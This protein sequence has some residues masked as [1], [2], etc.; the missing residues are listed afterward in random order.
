MIS[1]NSPSRHIP[2]CSCGCWCVG[3]TAP[4]RSKR[5]NDIISDSPQAVAITTPGKI[6]LV[7]CLSRS[8]KGSP[9]HD[10]LRIE[11][12]ETPHHQSALVLLARLRGALLRL[13]TVLDGCPADND[14]VVR[15][16]I[17]VDKDRAW[18]RRVILL[19]AVYRFN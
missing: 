19:G 13:L 16:A 12:A 18:L 15:R 14:I 11:A 17:P 4:A 2:I 3:T 7:G 10:P 6:S 8:K 9:L 1:S 5:T